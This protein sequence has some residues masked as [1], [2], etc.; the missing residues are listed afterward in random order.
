[1]VATVHY[2]MMSMV[3]NMPGLEAHRQEHNCGS[4]LSETN[5][6]SGGEEADAAQHKPMRVE[7]P[8]PAPWPQLEAMR[9]RPAVLGL[10]P[11]IEGEAEGTTRHSKSPSI[12]K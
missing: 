8:L 4:M 2:I 9:S 12:M 3:V 1:M 6:D 10:T 11:V 5:E 7:R